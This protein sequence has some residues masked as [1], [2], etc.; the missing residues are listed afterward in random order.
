MIN[1]TQLL[2]DQMSTTCCCVAAVPACQL[3]L[4]Q[5]WFSTALL[6]SC[7][8]VPL[9]T[10]QQSTTGKLEAAAADSHRVRQQQQQQQQQQSG[11]QQRG[12]H[13][14]QHMLAGTV[15]TIS[16]AVLLQEALQH[17]VSA[18]CA[19]LCNS[20]TL[21]AAADAADAVGF[22]QPYAVCPLVPGGLPATDAARDCCR[23]FAYCVPR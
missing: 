14:K 23:H 12:M 15:V 5:R 11:M 3:A 18:P 22:S 13:V 10:L 16:S 8:L 17:C 19:G 4:P 7:P 2:Y 21:C 9:G 6:S 1:I 20:Y